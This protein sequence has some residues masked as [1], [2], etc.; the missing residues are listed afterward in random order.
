ML[1]LR[2]HHLNCIPRFKGRGYSDEFCVNMR[3]IKE[4]IDRG[5]AYEIV[6]SADDI[7]AVCPN[8]ENGMCKSNDKVERFD[9]LTEKFGTAD[10]SRICSSCE[11]YFMCKN[12]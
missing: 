1:R 9:R 3:K 2:P 4:R 5:E 12:N 11:W 8:L 6:F 7:C 10:I